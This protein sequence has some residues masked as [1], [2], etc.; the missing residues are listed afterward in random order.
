M[1][2]K[3]NQ[4]DEHRNRIRE[5]GL[6]AKDAAALLKALSHETRLSIVCLVATDEKTV[7]EI[8]EAL[9][10]PQATISQ[11]IGRL[12]RE[13]VIVGQRRGRTVSYIA[14]SEKLRSVLEALRSIF[15]RPL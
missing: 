12:R 7:T 14:N 4:S 8:Q 3:E 9:Q 15:D 2:R 10:L 1:R 11:Q 6:I 13:K 5:L